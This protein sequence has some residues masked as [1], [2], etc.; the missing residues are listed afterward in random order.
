MLNNRLI[1]FRITFRCNLKCSVYELWKK[2]DI[3]ELSTN[4]WIKIIAKLPHFPYVKIT[5]G[6][7]FLRED[8]IEITNAIEEF[9]NPDFIYIISNGTLYERIIKYIYMLKNPKKLYIKISIDNYHDS[10]IKH[11]FIKKLLYLKKKYRFYL[12]INFTVFPDN[13]LDLR[14]TISFLN[15]YNLPVHIIPAVKNRKLFKSKK[16]V[17]ISKPPKHFIKPFNFSRKDMNEIIKIYK[18]K[19]KSLDIKERLSEGLHLYIYKNYIFYKKFPKIKCKAMYKNIKIN[20]DG[21]MP[22]CVYIKDSAGNIL[23]KSY[24]EILNGDKANKLRNIAVKCKGCL[25]SFELIP[26]IVC[27]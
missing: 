5:G 23:H 22:L 18:N 21:E 19:K 27:I 1:T 9:L 16:E 14:R 7:P 20:P 2:K 11:D 8:I 3:K 15:R 24:D 13:I 25:E 12:G 6:E 17:D 4:D 10:N 26:N